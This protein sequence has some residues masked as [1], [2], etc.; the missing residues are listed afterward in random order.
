MEFVKGGLYTI[1]SD[2]QYFIITGLKTLPLTMGGTLL[3]IGLFVGNLSMLFFLVGLLLITPFI[4]FII[5]LI[6]SG[7]MDENTSDWIKNLFAKDRNVCNVITGIDGITSKGDPTNIMV[8]SYW[9]AM[10]SFLIGYLLTNAG[11]L[12]I[13]PTLYPPSSDE[14]DASTYGI[15]YDPNAKAKADAGTANRKSQTLIGLIALL[16][17]LIIVIYLRVWDSCDGP[18]SIIVGLLFGFLGLG[19]YFTLARV[20]DDRLSDL[21]GIANRL[22]TPAAL[23]NA[24]YACLPQS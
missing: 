14:K 17:L 22:M 1:A 23:D 6:G 11:S 3:V 12:Y 8:V 18:V 15:K 9:M 16:V 5:N 24:P 20:G 4:V 21:F 7:F 19:W 2:F 10:S 13:K